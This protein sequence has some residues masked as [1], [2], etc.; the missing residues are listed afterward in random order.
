M[1][2]NTNPN[3]IFMYIAVVCGAPEDGTNTVAV[4]S[5]I[6]L[7]Y[8]QTYEYT[9]LPGYTTYDIVET[10]CLANRTFSSP[11]PTCGK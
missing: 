4:N 9:C 2:L 8:G 11:P 6:S 3:F 1:V 5:T 7:T 10:E